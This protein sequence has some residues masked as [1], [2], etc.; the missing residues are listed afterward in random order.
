MIIKNNKNN[1]LALYTHQGDSIE[2]LV[3][4]FLK[5]RG[6]ATE[7]AYKR[8]LGQFFDFTRTY[9]S[10]PHVKKGKV[11]FEEIRRVHI[12]KYK[13]FL[14]ASVSRK[15]KPFAP[16]TINRKLSSVSSFLQFL[17]DLSLIHI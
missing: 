4:E 13:K 5:D 12:V 2:D 7:K 3:Y 8:D 1:N 15:N 16:N 9:F 6:L 17:Y 10:I 14:E 11:L